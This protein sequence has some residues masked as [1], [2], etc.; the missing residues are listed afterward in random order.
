MSWQVNVLDTST[1]FQD[2]FS[3][4]TEVIDENL[5]VVRAVDQ[6][7]RRFQAHVD[8][9][10]CNIITDGIL[11]LSE[12]LDL[13]RRRFDD[14]GAESPQTRQR[15]LKEYA[16]QRNWL[17]SEPSPRSMPHFNG[18]MQLLGSDSSISPPDGLS[19]IHI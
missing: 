19:L 6:E 15:V 14:D 12:L 7:N 11:C 5:F 2:V 1:A 13:L 9:K 3:I 18:Q 8:S 10:R 4:A 16:E 17:L